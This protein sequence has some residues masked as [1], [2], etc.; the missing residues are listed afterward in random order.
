MALNWS[1]DGHSVFLRERPYEAARIARLDLRTGRR[2]PWKE[3]MPADP[4]GVHNLYRVQMTPDGR[5]YAHGYERDLSDLHLAEE[6][7]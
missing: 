1:P 4:A 5:Y 7:R 2:G 6:L 3:L